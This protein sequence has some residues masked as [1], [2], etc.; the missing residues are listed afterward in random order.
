M[1]IIKLNWPLIFELYNEILIDDLKD[2]Y[3]VLKF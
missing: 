2:Y 1:S 3:S